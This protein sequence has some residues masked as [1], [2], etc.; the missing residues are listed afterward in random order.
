LAPGDR[1][2]WR[3][4]SGFYLREAGEGE[5][6]VM[7]GT[8]TCRVRR[9]K[10]TVRGIMKNGA[11]QLGDIVSKIAMFK[12]AC[13]RCELRGRLRVARLIEQLGADMRLPELRY[14]LASNCPRVIADR[15][16]YRC[17]VHYP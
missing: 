14:I 6:E 2:R 15:V 10:Q 4:Y 17:G 1:V 8:R 3:E 12:V 16:Y 9:F 5:A 11:V 13:R 7:T